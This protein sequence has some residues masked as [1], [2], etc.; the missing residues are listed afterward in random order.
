MTDHENRI[1]MASSPVILMHFALL[2]LFFVGFSWLALFVFCLT[3]MVRVFALTAGFHRYFSH[4]SFKTSRIFQFILAWVGA[5]S[6]QKGPLWWAANHRYH[7]QH[8][9]TEEDI[10]SPAIR[11]FFWAHIGWV[12]CNRFS[13]LQ[14]KRIRDFYKYPEL[15]FLEKYHILAPLSLVLALYIL[16]EWL[17]IVVPRLE[18][19]GWQLV[20]WGFVL[21]TVTVYHVTFCVNSLTHIVG[22]RR[23]STRDE[24]RNN[25]WVAL[26][27]FGE[28]WHNNHHRY[29][30]SARQ[31]MYWWEVDITY[32]ILKFLEKCRLIWDLKVYPENI[33]R[34]AAETSVLRRREQ[35]EA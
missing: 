14:K 20:F 3:H 18:T 32:Y 22:K 34:E 10:H 19:S 15:R 9:D 5:S 35:I 30:A 29:S 2:G 31:G 26:F 4:R 17:A 24:S 23:F 7:H 33:Y 6:A 13:E 28:G 8:S 11:N 16:G 27:T 25:F 21:S 12:L 1:L